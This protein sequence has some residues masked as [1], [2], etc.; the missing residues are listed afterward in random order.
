MEMAREFAV[1]MPDTRVMVLLRHPVERA[2]SAY[3]YFCMPNQCNANTFRFSV[4]NTIRSC[5]R[6]VCVKERFQLPECKERNATP[7]AGDVWPLDDVDLM[8][9]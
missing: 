2:L 6:V 1:F 7:L 3:K 9:K 5:Q 8:K 4:R